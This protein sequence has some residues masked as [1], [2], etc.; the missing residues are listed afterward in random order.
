MDSVRTEVLDFYR[1]KVT[2]LYLTWL[3]EFS[4]LHSVIVMLPPCGLHL[5]GA[6]ETLFRI[7]LLAYW[8]QG[9][10]I[11]DESHDQDTTDLHKCITHIRDI[12]PNADKSN[13]S[14]FFSYA[15]VWVRFSF[16]MIFLGTFGLN[17]DIQT[18]LN[19]R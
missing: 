13:V 6:V 7:S 10:Q 8:M 11:V 1:S 2:I 14:W 12:T 3:G 18:L 16:I 19:P 9:T 5:F 15:P 4:F 17:H